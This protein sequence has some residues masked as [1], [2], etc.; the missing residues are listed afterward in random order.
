MSPRRSPAARWQVAAIALGAAALLGVFLVGLA[1]F[2]WPSVDRTVGAGRVEDRAVGR[3]QHVVEHGFWLVRLD[4]PDRAVAA[5]LDRDARDDR[6][7]WLD[8]E[9]VAALFGSSNFPAEYCGGI[10]R[11]PRFGSS[12]DAGGRWLAGPGPRNLDEYRVEVDRRSITV[13]LGRVIEGDS[14]AGFSSG[15][16]TPTPAATPT[17]VASP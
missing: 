3:P 2:L 1:A 10:F 8:A 9:A 4:E 12:Y 14:P 5:F 15:A 16:G 7:D 17:S 11:T 6:V 13:R